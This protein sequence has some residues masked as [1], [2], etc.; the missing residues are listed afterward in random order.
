MVARETELDDASP[1]MATPK[2]NGELRPFVIT[3]IVVALIQALLMIYALSR[4]FAWDEGFHMLAAQ[5]IKAG[6][7]PYIDFCFPQTPLNAYWNA[8]WM[9]I[10]GDSWQITHIAAA[11]MTAL[12]ILLVADYLLTRFPIARW[13]FACALAAA[14]L[15]GLNAAVVEF[16]TVGQAYGICMFLTVAA[17]RVAVIAVNRRGFMWPFLAALLMSAAAGC[18]MLTAPA[19]PVL[20]VWLFIYSPAGTRLVTLAASVAGAVVPFLPALWL[21][22]KAPHPVFFN[23][24]G[25]HLFFRR[26]K[27][28]GS[29]IHDF[30]TLTLWIQSGATMI[31][32]LLAIAGVL[33]VA[34]RSGWDRLVRAEYYLCAW[35]ALLNGLEIATARPTFAWY[36]IVIV[37]LLGILGAAGFYSIGSRLWGPNRTKWAI[38]VLAMLM[39]FA[40]MRSLYDDAGSMTWHDMEELAKKTAEVTPPNAPLWADEHIY[41][42]LKRPPP[43]GMEFAPA[44]KLDLDP[45]DAKKLH[46]LTATELLREVKAG[47]FDTVATCDDDDSLKDY[48]LTDLYEKKTDVGSCAVYSGKKNKSTQSSSE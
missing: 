36:F 12:A 23:L 27:W 22:W 21:A 28:E 4:A 37:P 16:G 30:E 46:I 15:I 6:Q 47:T 20:I 33:Y 25:Y 2:A 39:C 13:R 1:P 35:A 10:F 17:F 41:F 43:D 24:L 38:A 45:A 44:H 19:T 18:S 31:L 48:G 14:M 26:V 8:M 32:G 34:R 9:R 7:K 29:G 3:G 11:I 42:L 5:L 40:L